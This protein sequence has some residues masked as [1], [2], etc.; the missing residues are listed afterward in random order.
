LD[1]LLHVVRFVHYAAALQ[2]FGVA[3]FQSTLAPAPLREQ[4]NPLSRPL[5]FATAL[6]L[7]VS[8]IAW[9]A[10]TG[11]TMGG[12]W[13]DAVDPGVLLLVLTATTFGRVWSVQ[14]ALSLLLV[15]LLARRERKNWLLPS[16]LSG[17]ALCCLGLIGHA[18]IGEG[19]F[20]IINRAS[21]ALHILASGFWVG[22]LLPLVFCLALLRS[23]AHGKA[24]DVALHRFSGLGHLAVGI[25]LATGVV[26]SFAVLG[27][28][29][30]DLSSAYQGLLLM[31]IVLVCVMLGLALVNRYIFVP[32]IP[33]DGPGL[34]LLRQGTIA[35]IAL[36]GGVVGLVSVLGA[37]PP[38]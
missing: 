35:E 6:L 13:S 20:G 15:I 38:S 26:N 34:A 36:S 16:V 22:S 19:F 25:V 32:A 4:L 30:L 37:I 29:T 12:A 17:L 31:K 14:L 27:G 2:L 18:T 7:F 21:T 28:A 5:A 1:T 3:V 10:L 24:A 33:G 23:S 8:A 9:L 11:A